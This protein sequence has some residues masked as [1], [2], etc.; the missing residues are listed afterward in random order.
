MSQEQKVKHLCNVQWCKGCGICVMIC[1]QKV[2]ALDDLGK[3][4]VVNQDQCNNCKLCEFICPDLAIEVV[5]T[6]Q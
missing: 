3:V 2:L 4:K 1:P 5:V 6:G